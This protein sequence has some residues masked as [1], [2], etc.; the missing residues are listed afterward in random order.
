VKVEKARG[1][2][3]QQARNSPLAE[4]PPQRLDAARLRGRW[5]SPD[6]NAHTATEALQARSVKAEVAG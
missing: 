6:H 5:E 3:N 2:G 4:F 1:L